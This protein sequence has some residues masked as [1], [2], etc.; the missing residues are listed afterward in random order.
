M[1]A[2]FKVQL[3]E[4]AGEGDGAIPECDLAPRFVNQLALLKRIELRTD[5]C[6][7][8]DFAGASGTRFVPMATPVA[9]DM[10]RR[11]TFGDGAAAV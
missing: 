4:R 9:A 7:S 3:G 10:Q 2:T 8:N 6:G 11:S 5:A 1:R